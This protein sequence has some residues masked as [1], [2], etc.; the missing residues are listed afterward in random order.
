MAFTSILDP[1]NPRILISL[2]TFLEIIQKD[3][4]FTLP[5][6]LASYDIVIAGV[7]GGLGG[8]AKIMITDAAASNNVNK[9]KAVI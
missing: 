1:W 7:A 5:A 3:F 2:P 6:V 4:L 9:P 8:L